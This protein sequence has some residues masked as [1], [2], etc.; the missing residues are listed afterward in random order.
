M[1]TTTLAAARLA[2]LR[3]DEIRRVRAMFAGIEATR[4]AIRE[5]NEEAGARLVVIRNIY[6]GEYLLPAWYGFSLKLAEADLLTPAAAAALLV[7]N[8]D[9]S[10]RK[11]YVVVDALDEVDEVESKTMIAYNNDRVF[12]AAAARVEGR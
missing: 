6:G 10:D 9:E 8:F 2:E 4:R 5:A 7:E 12:R 1:Q 3:L 11:A